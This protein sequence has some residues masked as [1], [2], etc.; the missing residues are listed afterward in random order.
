RSY[1]YRYLIRLECYKLIKTIIE[2]KE[3]EAFRIW[4]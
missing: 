3:Y 4:W 1:S 2:K